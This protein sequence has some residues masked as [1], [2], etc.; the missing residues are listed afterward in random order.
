MDNVK[1]SNSNIKIIRVVSCTMILLTHFGSVLFPI[2]FLST[3]FTYSAEGVR[4]FFILSGYLMCFSNE[5]RQGHITA[6]YRKRFQ[7]ILPVYLFVVVVFVVL[8]LIRVIPWPVDD[9]GLYWIRYFF[10]FSTLVPANDI[11]WT[12][13]AMTWTVSYFLFFYLI[14]PIIYK[15][16]NSY[17]KAWT[18]VLLSM[19]CSKIIPDGFLGP[20]T[21]L[22]AFL[23][24]VT[25]FYAIKENKEYRSLIISGL[26]AFGFYIYGM[27]YPYGDSFIISIIILCILKTQ[28][29]LKFQ[30]TG[31]LIDFIDMHSYSIYLMQGLVITVASNCFG[32]MKT[33]QSALVMLLATVIIA[34][35][36]DKIENIIIG[37]GK[38]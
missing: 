3:F 9:T 16:V 17:A 30:I 12:N 26:I 10:F 29:S 36:F 2:S 6:Y 4:A 1:N 33:A 31:K 24:G 13:L 38:N 20:L 23:M 35:G 21:G 8:G 19:I 7:R 22:Y 11:Y 18:S 34:A 32:G 37:L 25:I 14:A 28:I 15:Y 27:A 5:L